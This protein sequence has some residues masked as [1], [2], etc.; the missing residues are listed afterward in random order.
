[1]DTSYR[2]C[3]GSHSR[4]QTTGVVRMLDVAHSQVF[5]IA[6]IGLM[7]RRGIDDSR[8]VDDIEA[9]CQVS[10]HAEAI[11]LCASI[12]LL[13]LILLCLERWRYIERD[14]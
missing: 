8:L 1:M 6:A 7:H 4:T 2:V 11:I 9:V 14:L 3:S 12:L 5:G 10:V 13:G